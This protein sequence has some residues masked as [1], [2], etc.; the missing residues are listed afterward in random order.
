MIK[1]SFSNEDKCCFDFI[2]LKVVVMLVIVISIDVLVIGILFVFV[3]INFFIF[4]FFFI[5]IIGFIFFVILILGSLIGVFCGKCF[6]LCMELWGGL[7]LI[8]IGVKI[9]IEYLF[10]F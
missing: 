8:I 7:V 2:K 6:N 10:F 9:L 4:I 1:E 3:G 5:V